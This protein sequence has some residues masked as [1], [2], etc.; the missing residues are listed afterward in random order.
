MHKID[1]FSEEEILETIIKVCNRCK[2]K[3]KI[4]GMCPEDI[5]QESY[6]ICIERL[7]KYDGRTTL[8]NFLAFVLCRRLKNLY[9]NITN[10]KI[11]CVS[12][13]KVP[14]DLLWKIPE[15][16][17]KEFTL[18]INEKLTVD[19]RHD[20]I[21]YIQGVFIPRVRKQRLIKELKR[22]ANEF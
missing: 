10:K 19:M 17:T 5:F 22:L 18:I 3:Y 7:H 6:I 9:R 1:G 12:I 2:N 20:Y 15:N 21:K 4:D 8:E 14:E 16:N 13:D 11:N